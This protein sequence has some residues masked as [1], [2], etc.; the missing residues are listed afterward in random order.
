MNGAAFEVITQEGE[1]VRTGLI[2]D[3][4]GRVTVTELEPGRYSFKEVG[5]VE[6]YIL[7]QELL[8]FV[9]ENE[10]EGKPEMVEAGN[11]INY[12]GSVELTKKDKDAHPLEGAL[13]TL[14]TEKDEAVAENLKSDEN[15]KVFV[16]E[17]S[18]GNYY[19]LEENAPEGYIK[20]TEKIA[21]TISE[22]AE[23]KPEQVT[24]EAVNYKGSGML[25]KVSES[26]DKLEG[27]EFELKEKESGLVI[28]EGLKTDENGTILVSGLAPGEYT[29]VEVKAPIG[30]V[31]NKEPMHFTVNTEY[32]GE[33]AVV[34]AGEFKNY[35][36]TAVLEKVD[37]NGNPLEGAIFELQDEEG[38]LIH[39]DLRSDDEGKVIALNLS[40]G[41]YRF[42][43][44]NAPEG[45]LVNLEVK[46][47]EINEE[48]Y[49]EPLAVEAGT[50]INYKGKAVLVKTDESGNPLKGAQFHVIDKYGK[51]VIEGLYSDENGKLSAEE[52]NPGE[53]F[54]EEIKA[55]EG[56]IRNLEKVAFA[57]LDMSHGEPEIIDAG[58]YINYKG[59][60]EWFKVNESGEAMQGARFNLTDEEGNI[61]YKDL[62]SDDTGKV[63]VENL[64]PG[65]Y[66][67]I[68]V[69]AP[70]GYILN[71]DNISFIINDEEV[72]NPRTV[73]AGN[74]IN[75][76]GSVIL[77]KTDA[78][79]L[80]L[81]GAVFE[82]KLDGEKK[83]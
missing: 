70:E 41:I 26:G 51:I 62:L 33:P 35:K 22:F 66:T 23:G 2:S 72:G 44:K 38:N 75:Y 49:G 18:S 53:Y 17:L 21:F 9:I 42:V 83:G 71:L 76:Q 37:A 14:Y 73:A 8:N 27:A 68:E 57:I 52:L 30:F 10:S 25:V 64:T 31:T 77:T 65:E 60:A 13:F 81:E 15:G 1:T 36:G 24:V 40:P 20:N 50:L 69:E 79:G 80:P 12:K 7:N 59:S 6:G 74:F 4:E 32:R 48:A 19:F 47:F 56:F 29:F 45:Y 5:S 82:L 78:L 43:E 34:M 39:T 28:V 54:F 11:L 55:P 63:M 3:E 61:V 46:T 58:S 16:D 67:I